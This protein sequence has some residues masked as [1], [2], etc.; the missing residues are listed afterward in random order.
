MS[1]DS[2]FSKDHWLDDWEV[3]SQQWQGFF[4]S[5]LPHPD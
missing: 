1:G 4:F 3:I 2:S 5:L